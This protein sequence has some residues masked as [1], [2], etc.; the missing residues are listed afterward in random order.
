MGKGD[1][2]GLVK[3]GA[4]SES[5]IIKGISNRVRTGNLILLGVGNM[6]LI[7]VSV[8]ESVCGLVLGHK[9]IGLG[10][11]FGKSHLIKE[12]MRK[13][14]AVYPILAISGFFIS[15]ASW[16]IIR[17]G[18]NLVRASSNTGALC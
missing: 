5:R 16:F 4:E 18:L 9:L 14:D 11:H 10:I 3:W 15:T 7:E 8:V 2:I 12:L 1:G 6:I 13:V 17:S